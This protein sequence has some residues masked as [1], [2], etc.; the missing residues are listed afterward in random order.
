MKLKICD[1][2]AAAID[3]LPARTDDKSGIGVHYVDPYL[4]AMNGKLEDGK[5]TSRMDM[6]FVN[7]EIAGQ[8]IPIDISPNTIIDVAGLGE[9]ALNRQQVAPN[10]SY[11]N[12]IDGLRITLDTAQA[13][14][15]IGAVIEFGVAAT[16][17]APAGTY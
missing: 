15:P 14:L 8:K 16:A 17:I 1:V 11:M 12:R 3:K 4:K 5:W 2:N 13:G 6:T 7:L 10:G 9:V